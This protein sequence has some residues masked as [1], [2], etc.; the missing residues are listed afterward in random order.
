MYK[1]PV[2]SEMK[3]WLSTYLKYK[4]KITYCLRDQKEASYSLTWEMEPTVIICVLKKHATGIYAAVKKWQ[5]TLRE[6]I[7]C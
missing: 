5:K 1:Y 7:Q 6:T 2:E 3:T 4:E